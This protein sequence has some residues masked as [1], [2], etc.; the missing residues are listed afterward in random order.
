[1][2]LLISVSLYLLA[3]SLTLVGLAE[4]TVWAPQGD[5]GISVS[6]ENPQPL[7]IIPHEILTTRQGDPVVS[8]SGPG[9]VYLATGREADI[10]AWIGDSNQ[11]EI[12][13]MKKEKKLNS[14][15]SSGAQPSASPNGSD[16]W[17]TERSANSSVSMKISVSDENAVIFASDGLS[18][19]PNKVT[20]RWHQTYDLVPSNIL[21]NTGFSLLL[22][23]L[24]YNLILFRNMRNSRRPRRKMPKAPQGPRSRAK[25]RGSSLPPRGRRSASRNLISIPASLA[26]ISLVA[27]CTS[28]AVSPEP[29]PTNQDGETIVTQPPAL[30]LGQIR[31]IVTSVARIAK[32]A[33]QANN[34]TQLLPRFTGPALEMRDAAYRLI[35]K[36]KKAPAVEPIFSSPLTLSLPAST[37]TWPRT[38]MVVTGSGKAKAPQMLVLSQSE[39]RKQYQV[40]YVATL[41]SG[42]KLPDVPALSQGGVPVPPDSAYLELVPNELPLAYGSLIDQASASTYFSKFEIAEDKFYQAVSEEQ[43]NQVKTLTKAKL[44]YQHTLADAVPLGLS[45]ADGGAL[46]AVFMKDMTTIKPLKRNSGITVN[47]IQQAALGAKGSVTGIVSTYGDMLLFY[48]PPIGKASKARLIGWQTGLLKVKAL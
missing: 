7:V 13:Y 10:L 47:E 9:L 3:L 23:T 15:S 17:R 31:R 38:L 48:V 8:V 33:D 4:R 5:Q 45:T 43:R 24:V 46:V 27:G 41:A 39:P 29:S 42:V 37:S 36:T 32:I 26:L 44:S 28:G 34:V 22:L 35:K 2:R 6:I 1:M 20:I 19:A 25:R 21:I 40:T 30:V 14:F 12:T 18:S 11:N 16:L